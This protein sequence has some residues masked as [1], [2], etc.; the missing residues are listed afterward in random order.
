MVD[1][2]AYFKRHGCEELYKGTPILIILVTLIRGIQQL[3][4]CLYLMMANWFEVNLAKHHSP[5]NHKSEIFSSNQSGQGCYLVASLL[6]DLGV[7]KS[8]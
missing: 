6:D 5:S 2:G 1:A 4:M 7:D 8:T 3:G